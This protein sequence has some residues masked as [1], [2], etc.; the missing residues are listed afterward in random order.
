MTI[1]L[2]TAAA[3]IALIFAA[4]GALGADKPTDP[5]IAHIAYTAG[6][7]DIEAAKQAIA[8]SK[9]KAVVKFAETMVRDH[10]AVNS[11]ALDL[12]KKLNVT[13]EDND[14]S[15]ALSQAAEA[16]RQ[17]LAKLT[18]AE[19]DKAYVEHEVAYHKQVN[20]A[21]ETMLIPAAQNGELKSLLETGLKLF[22]G[23]QQHAEHVATELK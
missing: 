21:L 13:P 15:K 17:E 6:V 12:V 18:G 14:T 11:Q 1:R 10:E 7:L 9:N 19:F 4:N 8:T 23:H 3:A 20:G 22:Q 2:T 16:K 5:Q